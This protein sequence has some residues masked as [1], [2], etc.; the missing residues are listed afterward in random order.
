MP[1]YSVTINISY[2]R[3]LV[4]KRSPMITRISLFICQKFETWARAQPVPSQ[5]VSTVFLLPYT[6]R[7]HTQV[8]V[9]VK[10]N[11]TGGKK[12]PC[13]CVYT[14]WRP[15]VFYLSVCP[16]VIK[17]VN[18]TF[19]NDLDANWHKWSAE[20]RHETINFAFSIPKLDCRPGGGIIH[21]TIGSRRFSILPVRNSCEAYKYVTYL[22]IGLNGFVTDG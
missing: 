11:G 15:N 2:T 12:R 16:S 18:V 6:Y 21:D 20:Q 3:T 13:R 10:A 9:N 14:G 8:K 22:Y 1:S 19:K 5:I 4:L 17:V 7:K